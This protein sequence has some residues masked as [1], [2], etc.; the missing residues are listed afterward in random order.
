MEAGI[1]SS[2]RRF[3]HAPAHHPPGLA[4][5]AIH[6]CNPSRDFGSWS[7][8]R[9]RG[10]YHL[11]RARRAKDHGRY[12]VAIRE[13]E[14]ALR[15]DDTSEA[16]YQVLAQCYLKRPGSDLEAARRAL[17]RAFEINPRNSYTIEMLSN[18]CLQARGPA[19]AAAVVESAMAAGAPHGYWAAVLQ[20]LAGSQDGIASVA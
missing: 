18:V 6:H 11:G 7:R 2:W 9:E 14:R 4:S 1:V 17:V 8:C 16:F 12:G 15:Y 3:F 13:I 10:Q 20:R 5:A 19:S